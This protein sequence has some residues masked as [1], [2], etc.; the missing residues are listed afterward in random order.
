MSEIYIDSENPSNIDIAT[1]LYHNIS[2]E[3]RVVDDGLLGVG[4]KFLYVMSPSFHYVLTIDDEE[5]ATAF[6]LTYDTHQS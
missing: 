1:W 6:R 5:L 3:Y 2:P 4:W